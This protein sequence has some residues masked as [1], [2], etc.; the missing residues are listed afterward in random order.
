MDK[1]LKN[2]KEE[3]D[4]LSK[5]VANPLDNWIKS[6]K[7]SKEYNYNHTSYG[8]KHYFESVSMDL[9]GKPF[10]VSNDQFKYAMYK[11]GFEPDNYEDKNWCFMIDE[12]QKFN[13][14]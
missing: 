6:L 8:I 13:W 7:P 2:L 4:K 10:T 3:Y 14:E 12:K 11:N 1:I 9:F 5:E